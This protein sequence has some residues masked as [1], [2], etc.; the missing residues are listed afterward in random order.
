MHLL[1]WS[2][3]PSFHRGSPSPY[4]TS[5]QSCACASAS[6]YG[7]DGTRQQTRLPCC[8][9]A[10]PN[11]ISSHRQHP[12]PAPHR[13]ALHRALLICWP[14]G[15]L[16]H[17]HVCEAGHRPCVGKLSFPYARMALSSLIACPTT[18]WVMLKNLIWSSYMQQSL[19]IWKDI[20]SITSL[21][22]IEN[23]IIESRRKS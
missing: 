19:D 6:S 7:Y 22:R 1:W 11:T 18:P 9:C 17:H 15:V 2:W 21:H 3:Q 10:C 16:R 8:A 4:C 14:L 13:W 20:T 5:H 23:D 12:R